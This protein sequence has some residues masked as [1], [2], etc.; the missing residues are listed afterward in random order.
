[1]KKNNKL[2]WVVLVVLIGAAIYLFSW[3]S[4]G[5]T[6]ITSVSKE[7]TEPQFT[8][9]GQLWFIKKQS[10]DTL[11]RIDIEIADNSRDRAQ[12]L[13]H[14]SAMPDNRGMLFIF[15]QEGEQSF[16]MKNMVMSI[17]IMYVNK[18]KEI[19]TIYKHAQPYSENPIPSF[20]KAM[21]VVETTAGFCDKYNIEEGDFIKFERSETAGTPTSISP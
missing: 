19:V 12:G 13:M 4:G 8:M 2:L 20:K 6:S 11:R 9:E 3:D 5:K 21:Y 1:M 16:W 15:D 7:I 10:K 17:D 18:N 14:R